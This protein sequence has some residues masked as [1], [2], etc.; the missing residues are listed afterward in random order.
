MVQDHRFVIMGN[1]QVLASS[2][3]RLSTKPSIADLLDASAVPPPKRPQA[4]K[5]R[6]S[7][8][9]RQLAR[10]ARAY[11][12]ESRPPAGPDVPPERDADSPA[13]LDLCSSRG[14]VAS[15]P[16]D[17]PLNFCI[18]RMVYCAVLGSSDC[19]V[20][21]VLDTPSRGSSAHGSVLYLGLEVDLDGSA[22]TWSASPASTYTQSLEPQD[23]PT[24]TRLNS[25]VA[26][27][28]VAQALEDF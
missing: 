24:S 22:R 12:P 6:V 19:L 10:S 3:L 20:A 28:V 11:A 23:T 9:C 17:R 2:L 13:I 26:N 7:A 25:I 5:R 8:Y 16:D 15:R 21:V 14:S 1:L 18:R 4:P 27:D